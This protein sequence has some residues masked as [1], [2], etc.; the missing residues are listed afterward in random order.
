[1][2]NSVCFLFSGQGSQYRQM[3]R[4]LYDSVTPFREFMDALERIAVA[5]TGASLIAEL[6]GDEWRRGDPFDRTGVTH[7]ALFMV[8]LSLARTL[9]ARGFQADAVLGASLGEYVAAVVSGAA[10]GDAM[11]RAIVRT[12]RVIERDC[13]PG[14]MLSVLAPR[15]LYD[16]EPWIRDAVT[17]VG[18]YQPNLF[19]V[20]GTPEN[21][22]KVRDHW[23]A[24]D[25]VNVMLPVSHAFHS[26]ALS[27]CSEQLRDIFSDLDIQS[28]HTL[29]YSSLLG[30]RVEALD[31]SHFM[32]IG[33]E[34][35]HFVDALQGLLG[36]MCR[37]YDFID[38][39]PSGSLAGLIKPYLSSDE[40]ERCLAVLSLF[41][42]PRD[43]YE[44]LMS[45][46]R[47]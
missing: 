33:V 21:I 24:M 47:L 38:L 14:A 25:I 10:D 20:S 3:G 18:S 19:V 11:M 27:R 36:G 4:E 15:G 12:A 45:R 31:A 7:P 39:G 1:M 28:P 40:K 37:G 16:E 23:T 44:K 13:P 43:Q 6:Y 29:F 42:N 5:E 9:M 46:G 22:R 8:Q 30:G 35:I 32:R 26:D 2:Q 41:T 17:F 34:P